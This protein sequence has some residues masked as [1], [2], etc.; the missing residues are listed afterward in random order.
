[1]PSASSQRPTA[2]K[3]GAAP[4]SSSRSGISM[5]STKKAGG[6]VKTIV[7]PHEDINRLGTEAQELMQVMQ[8][9]KALFEDTVAGY[10]KDRSVRTQEFDLKAQDFET[11]IAAQ[12]SL[13]KRQVTNQG[14]QRVTSPTQ[15]IANSKSIRTGASRTMNRY[16]TGGNV[17]S[18]Q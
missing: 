16:G 4:Q 10:Q 12:V 2:K 11:K 5:S 9:Q 15:M 14:N 1:M 6:V 7:L 3:G 8:S 18:R 17:S 13:E